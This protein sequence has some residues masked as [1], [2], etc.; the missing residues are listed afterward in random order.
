[1]GFGRFLKHTLF[2]P[3]IYVDII[4]NMKDEGSVIE[5]YKRTLKENYYE[6]NPISSRIYNAGRFEGKKEGYVDASQEYEKKLLSQADEY[7]NQTKVFEK[8]KD[9][10]EALLDEYEKEINFLELKV[11]KTEEEIAYLQE[12]L[13]RERKLRN[14]ATIKE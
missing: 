4:K 3:S 7:I 12:L 13:L 6:D 5:G 9:A 10:Y 2:P 1:M 11:D 14:I 8:E